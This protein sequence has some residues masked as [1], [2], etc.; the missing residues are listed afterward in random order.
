V[1][2]FASS[3]AVNAKPRMRRKKSKL[4]RSASDREAV[5][6]QT[7][8]R[9]GLGVSK[10]KRQ[11]SIGRMRTGTRTS[12][13]TRMRRLSASSWKMKENRRMDTWMCYETTAH[14]DGEMKR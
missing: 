8:L 5:Q 14:G 2:F 10:V 11:K 1:K 7:G 12:R 3:S 6:R 9:N 4:V 13:D